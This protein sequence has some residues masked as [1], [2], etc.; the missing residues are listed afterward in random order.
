MVSTLV[1]TAEPCEPVRGADL[2]EKRR[3]N[4]G[5]R[6]HHP[7]TLLKNQ[8]EIYPGDPASEFQPP[9]GRTVGEAVLDDEQL[10][11]HS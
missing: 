9:S 1:L 3:R 2:T 4:A 7:A 5:P 6:P 8:L 10:S 11:K